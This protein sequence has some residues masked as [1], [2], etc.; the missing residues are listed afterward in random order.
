[1]FWHTCRVLCYSCVKQLEELLLRGLPCQSLQHCGLTLPQNVQPPSLWVGEPAQ[2]ESSYTRGYMALQF[3]YLHA[4]SHCHPACCPSTCECTTLCSQSS[5][6]VFCVLSHGRV[7]PVCFY[8]P[9]S[10]AARYSLAPFSPPYPR[11]TTQLRRFKCGGYPELESVG[12]S[13]GTRVRTL[14]LVQSASL[15]I[16]SSSASPSC[17]FLS[18]NVG[19]LGLVCSVSAAPLLQ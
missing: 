9:A 2:G 11:T 15:H 12:A 4:C 19:L 8:S 10:P 3:V 16:T 6:S 13:L 14:L 7:M 18:H 1:M 5:M 17:Q